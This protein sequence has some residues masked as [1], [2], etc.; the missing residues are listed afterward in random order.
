M[1]MLAHPLARAAD[2]AGAAPVPAQTGPGAGPAP[3]S[4][5]AA[6]AAAPAPPASAAKP[7]AAPAAKPQPFDVLEYDI[8]GN[9]LLKPIDIERAVTPFLGPGRT[10][11]DIESARQ[12]LEKAYHDRGYKTVLVNIPQQ[13]VADGIVRLS[14]TEAPV[15]KLTISGSRFHSL[16]RIRSQIKQ[17]NPGSVPDFNQVQVELG[18]VNRSAD[19][20]VTPILRASDTPGQVDVELSVK[21]ELP[22]HATVEMD[23][24]YSANTSHTR[25]NGDLNYANLFQSD[26][27]A[28]FQ[29]QIAPWNP[30]DAEIWSASYVIPTAGHD[31][32][33][34]YA[35]HSDSNVAAVGGLDVIG[36]GDIFGVRFVAPLATQD[37]DFYHSLTAGVD[38]KDFKQSVITSGSTSTIESPV[39]YPAFTVQYSASW[40]GAAP[41]Q[42][43]FLPAA[44]ASG[45][46][47]TNLSLGL[48]FLIQ[49][50]GTNWRQFDNKR[51]GAT[52]SYVILHP[53]ISREQ[54]LPGRFTVAVTLDGQL[55]NGPL[56][57]NEQ[58]SAGGADTVR[59]YVESERLGD[60]G[61]RA[62]LELRSPQLLARLLPR[63]EQSYVFLF[64]DAARLHIIEPLPGQESAFTLESAGVG[65]KFRAAGVQLSAAGAR[66]FQA[67]AVTPAGRFRG[68]FSVSYTY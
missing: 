64:S 62:S 49:G 16:Q 13:R 2:Q 63:S 3:P 33:A 55:T 1:T 59:G 12:Q 50:L 24:R 68:L 43:P 28:S 19:L 11:R 7:A 45:R 5:A 36:K 30:S 22:V 21:D 54:V 60:E 27:S 58:Y 10:I 52:T 32:W 15:G 17:L 57:N 44:T 14:V 25:L 46:S 66:I 51:A 26:Q 48:S 29:Y 6:P 34:L 4:A 65:L 9:T 18:D 61:A 20:R 53:T 37:R 35:V 8:E 40:L 23:D 47:G 38:Y 67:G 42:A 41:A 56:I 39:S 31:A